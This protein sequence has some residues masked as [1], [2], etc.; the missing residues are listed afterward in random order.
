M[1]SEILSKK[2]L[3]FMLLFS[4]L[5]M[6]II[7][8]LV[9]SITGQHP[10]PHPSNPFRDSPFMVFIIGVLAISLL[11]STFAYLFYI[12]TAFFRFFIFR[13]PKTSLKAKCGAFLGITLIADFT[14]TVIAK[15]F[16]I[17]IAYVSVI[18]IFIGS[19]PMLFVVVP[20]CESILS[21]GGGVVPATKTRERL[22]I[23]GERIV[24]LYP[25]L[26][27]SCIIWGLR[28]DSTSVSWWGSFVGVNIGI[29][30]MYALIYVLCSGLIKRHVPPLI[31]EFDDVGESSSTFSRKQEQDRA[32]GQQSSGHVVIPPWEQ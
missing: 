24:I 10:I 15:L 32:V 30:S 21:R 5:L 18:L 7:G 6:G 23:V 11:Q 31:N 3:F 28:T 2:K 27:I 25:S 22:R 14:V 8:S 9:L 17:E 13:A 29:T 26:C 16:H 20:L 4:P 12:I 19:A 1:K